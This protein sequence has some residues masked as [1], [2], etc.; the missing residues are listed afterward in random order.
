MESLPSPLLLRFMG[1]R[2]HKFGTTSQLI[3]TFIYTCMFICEKVLIFFFFSVQCVFF[4]GSSIKK[5]NTNKMDCLTKY[6]NCKK[7]CLS[8]A[9]TIT[10]KIIT[11]NYFVCYQSLSWLFIEFLLGWLW[12]FSITKLLCHFICRFEVG[13][14]VI[15]VSFNLHTGSWVVGLAC[16]GLFFWLKWSSVL[17]MVISFFCSTGAII[18]NHRHIKFKVLHLQDSIFAGFFALWLDAE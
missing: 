17:R 4:T 2:S 18:L 3:R 6:L 11:V 10:V 12:A 8:L 16:P 15:F 5:N 1:T 13:P 14:H 7:E 9:V